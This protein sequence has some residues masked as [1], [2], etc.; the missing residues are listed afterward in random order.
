MFSGDSRQDGYVA[1]AFCDEE[2][3]SWKGLEYLS[4]QAQ[5]WT[6]PEIF[7]TNHIFP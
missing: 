7:W 5:G 3:H 1:P 4:V 6:A 2:F